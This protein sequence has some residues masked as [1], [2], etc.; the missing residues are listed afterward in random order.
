MF[1]D[2]AAAAAAAVAELN[3]NDYIIDYDNTDND[4]DDDDDHAP[5]KRELENTF[6]DM[7]HIADE[8]E[9]PITIKADR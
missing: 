8:F 6:N 1:S 5:E 3:E 9:L 4:Y 2:V 7:K